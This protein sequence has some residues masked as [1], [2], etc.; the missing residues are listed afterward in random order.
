MSDTLGPP[1]NQSQADTTSD[2]A[3]IL[4][5]QTLV[6]QWSRLCP[7]LSH[8]EFPSERIWKAK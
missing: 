5:E 7:E 3:A 6:E 4:A 8:I 1:K 2:E